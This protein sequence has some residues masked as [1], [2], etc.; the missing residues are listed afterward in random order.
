MAMKRN[1]G[2][3]GVTVVLDTLDVNQTRFTL[4]RWEI[5]LAT[6]ILLDVRAWY[7]MHYAEVDDDAENFALGKIALVP[8]HNKLREVTWEVPRIKPKLVTM[9]G[10]SIF[11]LYLLLLLC[12]MLPRR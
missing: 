8:E 4:P 9:G 11:A 7:R 2:N 10:D 1:I 5:A 6:A 12:C 3:A